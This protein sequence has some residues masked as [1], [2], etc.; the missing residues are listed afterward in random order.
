LFL[1]ITGKTIKH[2]RDHIRPDGRIDGGCR[3]D[4]KADD[5]GFLLTGQG[6]G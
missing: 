5:M 4:I 2:F 3:N 1:E 6:C